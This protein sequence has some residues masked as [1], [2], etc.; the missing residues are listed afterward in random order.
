MNNDKLTNLISSIRFEV[1]PHVPESDKIPIIMKMIRIPHSYTLF[2]N[3]I[4]IAV[5]RNEFAAIEKYLFS[6]MSRQKIFMKQD[7]RKDHEIMMQ[8]Y[9][10]EPDP[11]LSRSL[12]RAML[13]FEFHDTS[14][15]DLWRSVTN[16]LFSATCRQDKTAALFLLSTN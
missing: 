4:E 3:A 8:I 12:L 16:L 15:F 13:D 6:H 9:F 1:F 2:F 10:D 14:S 5:M 11:T 7:H